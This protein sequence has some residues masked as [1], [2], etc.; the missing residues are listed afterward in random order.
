MSM[1]Q[2]LVVAGA[3]GAMLLGHFAGDAD[4]TR[5]DAGQGSVF[6]W[7]FVLALA[8]IVSAVLWPAIGPLFSTVHVAIG[9]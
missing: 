9:K 7:L 1:I 8:V 5:R 4:R 3:I 2:F 6:G